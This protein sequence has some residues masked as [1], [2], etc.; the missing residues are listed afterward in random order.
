MIELAKDW[1]P[2]RNLMMAF[3]TAPALIAHQPGLIVC[4]AEIRTNKE[5]N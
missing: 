4:V 3:L 5:A 1:L 2:R